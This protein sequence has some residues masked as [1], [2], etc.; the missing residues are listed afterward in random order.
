MVNV[1]TQIWDKNGTTLAGPFNNSNFWAGLPGPWSSS[2]DGDPN[3][4]LWTK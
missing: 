4:S 2:N 1:Q 3:S